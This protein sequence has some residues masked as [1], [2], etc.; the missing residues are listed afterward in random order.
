[1]SN[2]KNTC[3]YSY[4]WQLVEWANKYKGITFSKANAMSKKQL[5]AIYYGKVRELV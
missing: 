2:Q 3:P 4:K 5:Y 1:M